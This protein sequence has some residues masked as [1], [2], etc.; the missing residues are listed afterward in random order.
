[1]IA[2]LTN[3]LNS[4]AVR[5]FLDRFGIW[6]VIALAGF[7][8][9]WQ[10][11]YPSKLVFDE[12]YYVKDAWTLW[13][14]GSEKAWPQDANPAFE[15]GQVSG[16]L[17]DPSFVVHPPLGKWIIGFGMWLFGSENS[18]SWRISTALL[19]I[20]AVGI[21]FLIA[22]Q[23]FKST[24]WALSAAFLFAIDGHAI[25][26]ARTALLDNSLMFF[27]L[28]AFYFLLKDQQ[29][30]NIDATIWFRPWL[31][32]SG[33]ALG[34]ATAVKW[35]GL[36][37]VAAF[38]LYVVIS[39]ALAR[40]ATGHRNVGQGNWFTAGVIKNGLVA[41][42]SL[43]PATIL[44]Y[45]ISWSGW[46]F[47]NSGYLRDSSNNWLIALIEY[48]KTAYG[49]HVGLQTP[50]AY[51]A[52][53]LSWIFAIRPTS[54]FYE[55]QVQ[56][57]DGCNTDGGCSSAITALGNPFIWWPA[58][59]SVFFLAVWYFKTRERLPGLILLGIAGGYLPWLLFMNRTTFQFYAIAFLPFMILA[60]IFVARYYVR[61]ALRPIKAQ[62][63]FLLYLGLASAGSLFFLTIWIGT[64]TPYWYWRL[65]MWL[66][67]WI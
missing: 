5:R 22:K 62:G 15:A 6:L 21:L 38:G 41:F 26:L 64:W 11:G 24:A 45:L 65:H 66:P 33:V 1:M 10:L 47:G 44:I 51:A 29:L 3:Y 35:S 19:G 9:L 12:T 4:N 2:S 42:I 16:Y 56:G 48:H 31:I 63:L 55:S 30:R 67:S 32:A 28:L 61:E 14:T 25:V 39:E 36:Y 40:K 17:S 60:L 57:Q 54:F 53:P 58:A 50:H 27:A 59:A 46:I 8:R 43:I 18:Y 34:A 49:F 7:L 52:N 23:L 20:A 13:N 37:F